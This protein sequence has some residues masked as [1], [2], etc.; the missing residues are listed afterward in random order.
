[1]ERNETFERIIDGIVQEQYVVMDNFFSAEEVTVLKNGLLE[2]Q[3]QQ[4]FK[5]SAIGNR[6]D[7]K[8]IE[9][10]RGD[11]IF[12]LDEQTVTPASA[13]FFK[14]V[15]ELVAYLNATCFLGIAEKE[16]HYA[17]YPEGTFYKRH[18]DVFQNDQRRRLSLVCYLNDENWLPEYGGEL[19]IYKASGDVTVY[20]ERG[21]VVIFDSQTL[22]HEVKPVHQKRY[23]ITG[24]LK[25]R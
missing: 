24:W 14:K 12:W 15:N 25:T 18:L 23:S 8:I 1:M 7:E 6:A 5:K 16:F 10:I 19:V 17:L 20:P 3:A 9:A 2:V 22:E 4:A 21:R 11:Y 13:L